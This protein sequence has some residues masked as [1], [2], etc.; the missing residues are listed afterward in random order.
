[1]HEY[2]CVAVSPVD[3]VTQTFICFEFRSIG[4]SWTLSDSISFTNVSLINHLTMFR[5]LRLFSIGQAAVWFA[6]GSV[7]GS[8]TLSI[9]FLLK[10][11]KYRWLWLSLCVL[12]FP[13][14]LDLGGFFRLL[15]DRSEDVEWQVWMFS[16]SLIL[17]IIFLSIFKTFD[18]L[19]F[20]FLSQLWR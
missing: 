12:N 20:Y 3:L 5:V 1:M 9:P 2:D 7:G 14:G 13:I 16:I 10:Y 6:S 11:I 15:P 18:S 4:G 17:W 8:S 19:E